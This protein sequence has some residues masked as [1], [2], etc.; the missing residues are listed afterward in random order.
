MKYKNIVFDFGNVI[1]KFDGKY[2]L[3]RFCSTQQDMDILLPVLFRNWQELDAGT[4]DYTENIEQTALLVPERLRD[5]VRDFFLR[6][7]EYVDLLPQTCRLISLLKE[8]GAR[9]FLLSNASVYF[10]E[11][12]SG[13]PV[14]ENF[15]GV[16]FSAPIKMAKP[17]PEIYLHLFRTF[18]LN[19]QDCFFIDDLGANIEAGRKLGMDGIIFT[20][21]IEEVKKAVLL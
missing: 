20:G 16:V 1:G 10:A 7:P 4:A 15:D 13:W 17:D 14:L 2:I 6:W 11:T 5:T 12:V 9:L 18:D 21:D 3:S 8:K 19:P